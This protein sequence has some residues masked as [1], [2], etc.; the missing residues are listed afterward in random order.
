ME[1]KLLFTAI[2]E[3][4]QIIHSEDFLNRNRLN[5]TFFT[6]KRKMDFPFI[7]MFLLNFLKLTLQVELNK[8]NK[9]FMNLEVSIT[10]SA[11]QGLEEKFHRLPFVNFLK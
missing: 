2:T 5:E 4:K 3:T 6:R 10:K 8:F 11:F 9:L 7:I 1:K